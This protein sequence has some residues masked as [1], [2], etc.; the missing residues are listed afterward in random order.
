VNHLPV[1]TLLTFNNVPNVL[2]KLNIN[3]HEVP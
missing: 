3:F 2:R 1:A